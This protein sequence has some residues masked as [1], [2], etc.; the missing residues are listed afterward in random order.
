MAD[1]E[2]LTT[3]CCVAG[4]GPAGLMLGHLLAR[5]GVDVLVLEKH[6]DF[7]RDFRGDTIHPSTLEVMHQLGLIDG[8]LDLPHQKLFEISGVF[9]DET[10]NIA[11]FRRL[12][13]QSKFIALMPQWDFL[14]FL[15]EEAGKYPNFTLRMSSEVTG[16]TSKNE[17]VAGVR[18]ET[19]A[20]PLEVAADLIV[21]AD[22]RHST[23]RAQSNLPLCDL[24]APMD[25]LWFKLAK[26][27]D[28]G[29]QPLGRFDRGQIL[30]LIDR[31]TY[32]QCGYIIPKGGLDKLQAE[33]FEAL[34]QG[35]A[36]FV[37]SLEAPLKQLSSWED[38][39]LLTVQVNRL[40][41]WYRPG[42]LCIGDAAHAM[43]PVGGIGVNLAIED[44]V[45]AANI[46]AGPLSS[47]TL[48][49]SHLRAV[50]AR[51]DWPTRMTQRIQV[52]I[53]KRL[54]AEVLDSQQK[55]RQPLFLRMMTSLPLL[56]QLPG[57]FIGL[58]LR[59]ENVGSLVLG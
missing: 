48:N 16:F 59:R 47:G 14:N 46:L 53:Q 7:L 9:G 25:V 57:R 50:Q 24:G 52:M 5:A 15:A 33:G 4:G 37:P 35:V 58:G 19:A 29:P 22:G 3:E 30:V 6:G 55:T 26:A 32:W 17:K 11:D 34:R 51:R 1:T 23:L 40:E 41:T 45:A 44:A 31:G 10:V 21:A 28:S 42:L 38:T 49:E 8:L 2:R 54:I 27:S 12:P 39:S 20:G 36:D 56:N 13:T 18:V 43:S